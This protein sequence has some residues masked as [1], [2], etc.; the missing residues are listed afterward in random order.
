MVARI[1]IGIGIGAAT[2][3]RLEKREK[4]LPPLS[5]WER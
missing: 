3:E 2:T 5:N 4:G 1:R